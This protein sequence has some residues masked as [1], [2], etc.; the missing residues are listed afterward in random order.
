MKDI[1]TALRLV[2]LGWFVMNLGFIINVEK[3]SLT[4]S[5]ACKFLGFVLNSL[6]FLVELPLEKESLQEPHTNNFQK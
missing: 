5:A 4:P 2:R 1:K 3:S 6:S